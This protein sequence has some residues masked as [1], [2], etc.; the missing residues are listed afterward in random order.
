MFKSNACARKIFLNVGSSEQHINIRNMGFAYVS[1]S[2][3]CDY[4]LCGDLHTC[5]IGRVQVVV[6]L[7]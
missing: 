3:A 6:R 7:L 2:T 5:M 1:A 4:K